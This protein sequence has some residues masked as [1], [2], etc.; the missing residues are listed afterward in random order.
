MDRAGVARNRVGHGMD[1]VPPERRGIAVAERP[2][3]RRLDLAVGFVLQPAPEDVVFPAGIDADDGHHLVIVGHDGHIRRP[4]DVD[5]RKLGRMMQLLDLAA[6]RLAQRLDN[7]RRVRH[8]PRHDLGNSL[9]LIRLSDRN[10]AIIDKAR[11]LKHI[12][13]LEISRF[14]CRERR[15]SIPP[16]P[17]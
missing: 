11:Q 12:S 6:I 8:G 9:L 16:I 2:R 14:R 3:A 1:D 7:A 5:D 10:R 4:D 17:F 15:H 13:L